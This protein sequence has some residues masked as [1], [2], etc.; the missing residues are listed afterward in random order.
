MYFDTNGWMSRLEVCINVSAL[1]AHIYILLNMM[2]LHVTSANSSAN[3]VW[4]NTFWDIYTFTI[5]LFA[6]GNQWIHRCFQHTRYPDMVFFLY[7]NKPIIWWQS[8]PWM[9]VILIWRLYFW[10]KRT[11]GKRVWCNV[12]YT[13]HLERTLDQWATF[14]YHIEFVIFIVIWDQDMSWSQLSSTM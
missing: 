1:P 10:A 2:H 8:K 14:Y 6:P 7:W 4:S 5:G 9:E 12:S 11:P 3:L 13:A